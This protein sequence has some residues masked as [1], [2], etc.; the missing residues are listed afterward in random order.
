MDTKLINIDTGAVILLDDEMY[1]LEEHD[2]SAVVQSHKYALDGTLIIEQ[3]TRQAGRPYTMQAPSDL[4]RALPRR[5]VN[6]LKA[7][8]DKLGATFWLDYLADGVVRRVK[9]AFDNSGGDAVTAKP[10]YGFIS[11]Q[12]DDPFIV[13]LK[14]IE[15]PSP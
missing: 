14:F 13:T 4:N 12:P 1:P 8:R 11:P 10:A 5:A 15:L 3:S 2:W 7:E 9:V 6:L